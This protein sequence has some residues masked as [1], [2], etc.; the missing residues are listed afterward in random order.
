MVLGDFNSYEQKSYTISLTHGNLK[1]TWI[2]L[3]P[4]SKL[5]K[6]KYTTDVFM[7]IF[8]MPKKIHY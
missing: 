1:T 3:L 4:I 2:L 8:T 7:V 6:I 5:G